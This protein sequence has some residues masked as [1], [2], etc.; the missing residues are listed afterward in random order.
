MLCAPFPDSISDGQATTVDLLGLQSQI[1][2]QI[3][4]LL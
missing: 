4:T 2:P 1:T 3:G